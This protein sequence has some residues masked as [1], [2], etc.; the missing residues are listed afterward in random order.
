MT[1]DERRRRVSAIL[2]E[3]AKKLNMTPKEVHGRLSG[4]TPD[5]QVEK[6]W[7]FHEAAIK[8]QAAFDNPCAEPLTGLAE[9]VSDYARNSKPNADYQ[10]QI[11]L[12][13]ALA[14]DVQRGRLASRELLAYAADIGES[15]R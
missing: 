7:S 4:V 3:I 6:E 11:N 8:A 15:P 12:L 13:Y 9:L 5:S 14:M 1:F 10:Q 2:D